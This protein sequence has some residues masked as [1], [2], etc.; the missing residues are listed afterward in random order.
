MPEV[1][2]RALTAALLHT[3]NHA[4]FKGLLFLGAGALIHL[5]V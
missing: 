3:V 4:A 5:T 1:S 2:K